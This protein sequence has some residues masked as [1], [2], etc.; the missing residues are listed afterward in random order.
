MR[1]LKKGRAFAR[2]FFRSI[3]PDA[4]R[5]SGGTAGIQA[6]VAAIRPAPYAFKPSA[7]ARIPLAVSSNSSTGQ[8][9]R[10]RPSACKHRLVS[11]MGS[12]PGW[13]STRSDFAALRLWRIRPASA[14]AGFWAWWLAVPHG[15]LSGLSAGLASPRSAMGDFLGW[16]FVCG[17]LFVAEALF[18]LCGF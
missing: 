17:S 2:P 3:R 11:A 5:D 1:P 4:A 10:L 18:L 13:S 8:T 6:C 16:V 7:L 12:F 9:A 15:S 14:M